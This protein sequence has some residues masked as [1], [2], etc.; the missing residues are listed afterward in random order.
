MLSSNKF[1]LELKFFVLYIE[2]QNEEKFS[3]SLIIKIKDTNNK[4][5]FKENLKEALKK[6]KKIFKN[7]LRIKN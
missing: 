7:E 4:R 6:L 3:Q 5:K 1:D 2:N